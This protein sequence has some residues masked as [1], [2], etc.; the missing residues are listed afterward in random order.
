MRGVRDQAFDPPG[1]GQSVNSP[2]GHRGG[3]GGQSLGKQLVYDPCGFTGGHGFGVGFDRY[4]REFATKKI[5]EK[6]APKQ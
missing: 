2:G 3:S 4:V 6:S 5:I 1:Q